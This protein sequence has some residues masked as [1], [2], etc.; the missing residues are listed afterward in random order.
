MALTVFS[1]RQCLL[2]TPVRGR[3]DPKWNTPSQEIVIVSLIEIFEETNSRGLRHSRK[4]WNHSLHDF[5]GAQWE[6]VWVKISV[7]LTH[8]RRLWDT[9]V[10][11]VVNSIGAE[12]ST[13]SEWKNHMYKVWLWLWFIMIKSRPQRAWRNHIYKQGVGL[14]IDMITVNGWC[15][16]GKGGEMRIQSMGEMGKDF[17]PNFLQPFLEN[18]DRR[19]CNDGS[20]KLIPIF[21]NP[22]R[23]C[24][25]YNNA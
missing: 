25:P 18:I 15:A 19:S 11:D 9:S 5:G 6:K 8:D 14:R 1:R 4:T 2:P 10:R 12:G 24:R 3:M 16:G 7:E 13:L 23:K 20:R 17:C 22:H 21:H